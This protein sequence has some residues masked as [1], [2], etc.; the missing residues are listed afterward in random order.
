VNTWNNSN[1]VKHSKKGKN[2]SSTEKFTTSPDGQSYHYK[3][4]TKVN[5][6]DSN[7]SYNHTQQFRT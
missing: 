2:W 1:T 7:L 6:K 3:S 4:E 5:T